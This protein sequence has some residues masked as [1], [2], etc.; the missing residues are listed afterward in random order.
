MSTNVPLVI[1][2]AGILSP[3]GCGKDEFWEGV[4]KGLSGIGEIT[5]FDALKYG[6]KHAG[7]IKGF[8]PESYIG[9]KGLKYLARTT[10]LAMAG[11][12]LC[13]IDAGIKGKEREYDRYAAHSLGIVLGTTLGVVHS[14]YEFQETSLVEGPNCV[15]PMTFPNLVM[16][17]FAGYVAIKENI[18]GINLTVSTGHNASLDAVGIS[19]SYLESDQAK[20]LL[21]G[22]VEELSGELVLWQRERE[23]VSG[24]VHVGEGCGIYAIEKL[25]DA[26]N[27]GAKIYGEVA[28]YGNAFSQTKEGLERAIEQAANEAGMGLDEIDYIVRGINAGEKEKAIESEVIA[29]RFSSETHCLELTNALGDSY[30][31]GGSLQIGAG[32]GLIQHKIA[33]NFLTVSTDLTGSSSALIIRDFNA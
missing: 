19:S 3:I 31:A 7:E 6:C 18:K 9:K 8:D 29:D 25:E 5:I 1:T 14:I 12:Y 2:G 26:A 20:C 21:V 10:K 11:A 4:G 33:T 17:S 30:S 27:R 24:E 13:L 28:G 22:G 16:N 23:V 15:S 32:L